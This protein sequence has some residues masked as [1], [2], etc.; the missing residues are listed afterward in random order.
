MV[1]YKNGQVPFSVVS[2]V[3]A[4]GTNQDGYWEMRATPATA[5]RWRYAKQ[6]CVEWY[7][8]PIYIVPGWNIYRPLH[9]Q[10]QARDRACRSGNCAGAAVPGY[11]SHGGNWNGRD[12]LAIDVAPNGLSWAQIDKAMIAAGFAA[13]LI[14]QAISGIPGGE[15][16]HYID[17][18]A[19]GPVPAF[20]G[21]KPAPTHTIPKEVFNMADMVIVTEKNNTGQPLADKDRRAAFVNT[22]SGFDCLITWLTLADADKW[23]KQVG[24]PAGALRM[25]DAGFDRFRANL[26]L[27]RK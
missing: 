14:T 25:S 10:Q 6:L 20:A 19:F 11:S 13:G 22:D 12:C 17:F 3:L 8:R 26:A 7:G 16:W 23:A 21:A 1:L 9:I 5:A 15:P 24:M 4:S 2:E 18:A 27:V